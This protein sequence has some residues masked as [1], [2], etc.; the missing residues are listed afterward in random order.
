MTRTRPALRLAPS[1]YAVLVAAGLSVGATAPAAAHVSATATSTAAG[2]YTQIT[3]SVP[4]ES[5]T[6]STDKLEIVLPTDTPFSSV[7][8]Q[9][10]HGW[11]AEITE[12]K[13]PEPVKVGEGELTEA[14][15]TITWTAEAEHA[16]GPDEFQTFTVSV[17][18]LPVD[19]GRTILLPVTQSYTDGRTVAWTDPAPASGEEPAHPA[20]SLTVTAAEADG[21][22]HSTTDQATAKATGVATV[23]ATAAAGTETA[24][25][26]TPYAGAGLG[27]AGLISGLLGLAAG[28]TALV[29]A[30]HH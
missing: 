6:A 18:P 4:T 16:I 3:F 23:E 29:R 21:H 15:S 1:V 28:L 26:R 24:S 27:W 22:A 2:G 10:V 30:R 14:A 25:V 11:S 9:P 7:R 5:Q 17:G 8:V 20:P 13:L 19:E 12:E